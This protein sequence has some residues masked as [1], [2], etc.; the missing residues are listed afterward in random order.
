MHEWLSV[1]V[2]G[3]SGDG[4]YGVASVSAVRSLGL[5][6]MCGW[7]ERDREPANGW[8]CVDVVARDFPKAKNEIFLKYSKREREGGEGN[9]KKKCSNICWKYFK[10]KIFAQTPT[11][12]HQ[13]RT[14]HTN[15]DISAFMISSGNGMINI[16][17]G[18]TI[19]LTHF[20]LLNILKYLFVFLANIIT[21]WEYRIQPASYPFAHKQGPDVRPL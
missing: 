8:Y 19:I 12:T 14:E 7:R 3:V 20:N 21:R 4:D 5:R 17:I 13:N 6:T 1:Y 2:C 11:H 15:E 9:G 18:I 10:W 16:K